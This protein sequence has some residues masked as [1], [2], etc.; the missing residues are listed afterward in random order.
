MTTFL[1]ILIGLL[2]I[3]QLFLWFERKGWMYWRKSESQNRS[4][5]GDVLSG[6]N[7]MFNPNYKSAKE[8][9]LIVE[10]SERDDQGEGNLGF[11]SAQT[12]DIPRLLELALK[13]KAHWGYDAAFLKDCEPDLLVAKQDI[14]KGWVQ[15]LKKQNEWIGYYGF[16]MNPTLELSDFFID[17]NFIGKGYGKFLWNH[18]IQFARQNNW[19]HF[20]IVSDPNALEF[21]LNMGAVDTGELAPPASTGRRLPILKLDLGT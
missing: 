7:Q 20:Q 6:L 4:G 14:E 21:Y 1:K 17:P 8:V 9:Q 11:F 5:G 3:D 16:S 19:T 15:I 13:S 2:A 12:K 10:A 18:A